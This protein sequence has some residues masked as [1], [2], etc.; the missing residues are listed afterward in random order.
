VS[1]WRCRVCEGVN[2][3]G[4]VCA[5]CGAE[6]PVGEPLRAAVRTRL[7]STTP[8]APAPVPPLP[9]RSEL[10]GYPTPEEYAELDP[11]ETDEPLQRIHLHSAARRLPHDLRTRRRTGPLR[12]ACPLLAAVV[13]NPIRIDLDV[14]NR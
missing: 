3:G 4:R 12:P 1:V 13:Y 5:T 10:Y 14:V 6:V 2:Q 9:S 8:P 11:Y 7:P